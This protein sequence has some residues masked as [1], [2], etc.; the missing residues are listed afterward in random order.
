MQLDFRLQNFFF[1]CSQYCTSGK[2]ND[3]FL[4]SGNFLVK[5]HSVNLLSG[6]FYKPKKCD[7]NLLSHF[8]LENRNLNFFNKTTHNCEGCSKTKKT[9]RNICK[10]TL[11]KGFERDWLVGLGAMLDDC[12]TENTKKY[13]S[14]FRDF[15]GKAIMLC[16]GFRMYYKATKFY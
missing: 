10:R 2:I 4:P 6:M 5:S 1:F 13:F 14:S 8:F 12:H 9:P 11:D 3:F 15:P 16:C 7:D